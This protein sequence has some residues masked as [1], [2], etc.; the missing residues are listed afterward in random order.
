[1]FTVTVSYESMTKKYLTLISIIETFQILSFSFSSI[2][3]FT[4]AIQE[5]YLIFEFIQKIFDFFLIV[6]YFQNDSF[7]LYKVVFFIVLVFLFLLFFIFLSLFIFIGR[8]SSFPLWPVTLFKTVGELY[9]SIL[10]LPILRAIL[11]FFNCSRMLS[12]YSSLSEKEKIFCS[13]S[14]KKET[15]I[16]LAA[17]ALFLVLLFGLMFSVLLFDTKLTVDNKANSISAKQVTKFKMDNYFN[18]NSSLSNY[19]K[20]V[21]LVLKLIVSICFINIDKYINDFDNNSNIVLSVILCTLSLIF[22]FVI[23]KENNLYSLYA[24]IVYKID[25]INRVELEYLEYVLIQYHKKRSQLLT[26]DNTNN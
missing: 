10:I 19:Y 17:I 3:K 8:I 25:G 15:Y 12:V 7:T 26:N 2:Y 9:V 18:Y 6:P 5:Y 21:T 24:R 4:W 1:M 11:P 20:I 14:N 13:D 23:Y 16:A 22:W